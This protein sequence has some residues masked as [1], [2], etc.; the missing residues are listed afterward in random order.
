MI[1]L[2][3]LLNCIVDT[4]TVKV[5]GFDNITDNEV[6]LD[7]YDGRNSISSYYNNDTVEYVWVDDQGALNI[8][9][10]VGI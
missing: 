7:V 6:V 10:A 8:T 5:W 4:Q 2:I 1:K 9:I 3:D